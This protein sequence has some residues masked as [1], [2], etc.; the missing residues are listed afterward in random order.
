MSS[1]PS[2][3]L[4]LIVWESGLAQPEVDD[5]QP[6]PRRTW[7][8]LDEVREAGKLDLLGRLLTKGR[9]KGAAV[10]LGLQDISGMREAYGREI[11]DELLGQCN[12]KVVLRLNS[13]ETAAWAAKLC[14]NREVLESHHGQ[15]R[16]RTATVNGQTSSGES[17]S[18]TITQRPLILDSEILGLPETSREHGLIAFFINPLT[19]PFKDHLES[20]WLSKHLLP[21]DPSVKNFVPRPA[22]DQYLRPWC[23]DD[24]ALLGFD[25]HRREPPSHVM[26]AQE[27]AW[28]H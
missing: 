12:T 9:S 23:A 20:A 1:S 16:N 27:N 8:F 5:R 21:A 28:S 7:F 3:Y 18:H 19:G 24:D 6:M 13:P 22:S 14:G 26:P 10:S 4:P 25:A 11:A 2:C 17:V 15:S